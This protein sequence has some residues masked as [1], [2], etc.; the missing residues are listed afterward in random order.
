MPFTFLKT[1]LPGVIVIEPKLYGDE[2]GFFL[3]S[4]KQ[5]DFAAAGVDV[6]FVQENHSRSSYGVLR[7][8]HY[9]RAPRAQCK[10]L[11]VVAGE[12]FDVCVDI[13]GGSP[14]FG[15][16]FGVSLSAANH[17]SIYI[18]PRVAHALCLVSAVSEV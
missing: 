18:P 12:I 15:K 11:R 1:G 14:T 17:K 7:G 4:Y 10:L 5:S 13:R 16:W 9:Q 3:E 8:L 6:R 2:R